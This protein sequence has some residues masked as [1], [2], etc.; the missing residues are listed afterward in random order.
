MKKFVYLLF[1][2]LLVSAV[3]AATLAYDGIIYSN[4]VFSFDNVV[5]ETQVSQ[6]SIILTSGTTEL[7]NWHSCLKKDFRKF[8][9]NTSL[10]D[11]QKDEYSAHIYIYYVVPEIELTRTATNNLM[12]FGET[13]EFI[14]T[15]ENTGDEDAEDVID[16][17]AIINNVVS[18][19]SSLNKIGFL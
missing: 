18:L 13:A 6:D 10:Y 12:A 17:D 3:N 14:A 2:I 5:Y 19:A 16:K 1:C 4:S 15:L 11:S 7:I 9:Y 8:C